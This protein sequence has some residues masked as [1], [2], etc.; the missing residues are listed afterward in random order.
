MNF[1]AEKL[2]QAGAAPAAPP[3]APA[4]T[5][6]PWWTQPTYTPAAPAPAAPPTIAPVA[7]LAPRLHESGQ[8]PNCSS[9]NYHKATPN[10]APRCMDCGYPVMHSTSGAVVPNRDSI[11]ARASLRQAQGSKNVMQII[12]HV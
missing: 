5:Q 12:G 4:A 9:G 2:Q 6:T 3:P 10:T 1:W 7:A 11:P 8:C